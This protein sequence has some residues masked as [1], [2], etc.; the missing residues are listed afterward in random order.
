MDDEYKKL[1]GFIPQ[2]EKTEYSEHNAWGEITKYTKSKVDQADLEISE[3]GFMLPE[4]FSFL[5]CEHW[6]FEKV[7]NKTIV[8]DF[9]NY[10]TTPVGLMN[11]RDNQPTKK[12]LK[13]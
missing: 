10:N 6:N 8:P 5:K 9:A 12:K 7:H 13:K 2:F 4:S 11:V 1:L 3:D